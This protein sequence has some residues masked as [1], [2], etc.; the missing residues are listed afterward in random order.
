[1]RFRRVS[2]ILVVVMA[3]LSI[4]LAGCGGNSKKS[5][6]SSSAPSSSAPSNHSR[7]KKAAVAGTA[8][9]AVHHHYGQVQQKKAASST[10]TYKVGEACSP[11][12]ASTYKKVGLVCNREK[13]SYRLQK[14]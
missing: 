1:M 8:A 4:G 10:T 5:S 2:L 14:P 9:L 12:N 7:A 11:S 13:N 6:T 3:A